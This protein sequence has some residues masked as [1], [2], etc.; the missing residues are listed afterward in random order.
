MLCDECKKKTATV[1]FKQESAAGTA[2]LHLCPDCA[3]RIAGQFFS[4]LPFSNTEAP[5]FLTPPAGLA[6]N[7]P[8]SPLLPKVIEEN[9]TCSACGTT[10]H[11]FMA[12]GLLCCSQCYKDFTPKIQA[13]IRRL[14][15]SG[16]HTGKV[17]SR[18]GV[19]ARLSRELEA[20]KHELNYAI[21]TENYEQAAE[22]RDKI[23]VM[24]KEVNQDQL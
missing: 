17:P 16:V 9:I 6:T 22:L 15:G 19:Q 3:Q 14:Q 7:L 13:V 8:A 24:E 12:S 5:D 4:T 11:G 18:L 10:F 23:K 2:E 1:Y 20:L 21:S